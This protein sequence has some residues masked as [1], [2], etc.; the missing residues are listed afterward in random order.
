MEVQTLF[1]KAQVAAQDDKNIK[2]LE[3]T[4]NQLLRI[5]EVFEGLSTSKGEQL[6]KFLPQMSVT[7]PQKFEC[8]PTFKRTTAVKAKPVSHEFKKVDFA[9]REE[10]KVSL[11]SLKNHK[12][13]SSLI[14]I[15]RFL[16]IH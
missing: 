14:L 5:L 7:G 15:S 2:A 16:M 10:T 12:K 11:L 3:F 1:Q 8:Q 9:Q 6:E 4:K 13:N